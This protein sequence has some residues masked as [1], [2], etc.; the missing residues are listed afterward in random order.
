M[1]IKVEIIDEFPE[2]DFKC[3]FKVT[4]TSQ[5]VAILDVLNKMLQQVR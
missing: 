1:R 2:I 4:D 5:L 3:E